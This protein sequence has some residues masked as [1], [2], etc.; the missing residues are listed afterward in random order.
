M[1]SFGASI[2]QS[3]HNFIFDD[4]V[5]I[6]KNTDITNTTRPLI[7]SLGLIVSHDFWGQNLTSKNSHKS[8]RPLISIMY[9]LEFRIFDLKFVADWMR[10][11]NFI[12]HC[13]VC[14][15]LGFVLRQILPEC[16]QSIVTVAVMIFAIHPIHTEC[17]CSIV[18]RADLLCAFIFL[19]TVNHYWDFIKG[20][21]K[22]TYI[23]LICSITKN[24]IFNFTE[25]MKN[26]FLNITL[27]T[28]LSMLCIFSKEIGI[29]V[30][31]N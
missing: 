19:C 9:H 4:Q 16:H 11:V 30:L 26:K 5:A 31:V 6:L 27:L 13:G 28:V 3:N 23:F 7:K 1:A 21:K 15:A 17:I 25:Q 2:I 8:Y 24:I 22:T 12:L 29:A 18:G 14:N 20:K 10:R